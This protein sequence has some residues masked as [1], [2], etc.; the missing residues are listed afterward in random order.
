[1]KRLTVIAQINSFTGY[2]QF[3][4]EMILGLERVARCHI[5]VRSIN[6]SELFGSTVPLEI[7]QKFV[8]GVQPEDYELLIHPPGFSP[9]AGKKTIYYGMWE[10]T[11]LPKGSVEL[12]NRCVA[13]IVPSIWNANCFSAQG[14]EVPIYIVP[15]GVNPEIF[16]YRRPKP[17]GKFVVGIAGRMAHGGVRKG[18]NESIAAFLKAFPDE[19]DVELRVKC[20]NDCKVDSIKDQR[21]KFYKEFLPEQEMAD[22][23]AGLDVF[24]SSA[25]SEGWGLL[26]HQAMA[27]G[28][29][30]ISV[31]Y[32]GIAEFFNL[33]A[34]NIAL[35]YSFAPA[36]GMYSGCGHWAEPQKRGT[37]N[38]L[39]ECYELIKPMRNSPVKFTGEGLASSVKHLTWENTCRK[40]HDVLIDVG[41]L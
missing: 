15:L 17:S 13:V 21:V 23:L 14:V 8:N 38:A 2:G 41:A 1:M 33:S 32:G 11:R 16:H 40:L 7:K 9:T 28:R 29:P 30:V 5:S 22:W 37:I 24:F 26:Q 27:I 12:I 4:N 35:P 20:F 34:A 6:T 18:I 19:E 25:C 36:T 3:T 39:R 31:N 10:T